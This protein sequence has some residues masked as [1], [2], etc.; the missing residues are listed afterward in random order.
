MRPI[1]FDSQTEVY[2]YIRNGRAVA[3][4]EMPVRVE[5]D[6]IVS[7]WAFTDNERKAIAAGAN[8]E[9]KTFGPTTPP[10]SML[11]TTWEAGEYDPEGATPA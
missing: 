3:G 1:E 11:V 4:S 6:G 7:R 8:I 10:L 9:L 5:A 2:S